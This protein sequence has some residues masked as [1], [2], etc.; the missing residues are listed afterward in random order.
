MCGSVE[1]VHG[2]ACSVEPVS[3]HERV[4]Q[5]AKLRWSRQCAPRTAYKAPAHR[6]LYHPRVATP[7]VGSA[8][9]LRSGSA[10]LARARVQ[11]AQLGT[12]ALRVDLKRAFAGS[13]AVCSAR[14]GTCCVARAGEGCA[15]AA[16]LGRAHHFSPKLGIL[17]LQKHTRLWPTLITRGPTHHSAFAL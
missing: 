7:G 16:A 12:D 4:G 9:P 6:R 11:L 13:A 8:H 3:K 2:L 17:C 5:S 15:R 14:G 10:Q 1:F